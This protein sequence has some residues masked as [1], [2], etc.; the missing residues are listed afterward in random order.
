LVEAQAREAE[1]KKKEQS[2][3]TA[4]TNSDTGW[5]ILEDDP[6]R[7]AWLASDEKLFTT[8]HTMSQGWLS[9]EGGVEVSIEVHSDLKDSEEERPACRL[10]VFMG[11]LSVSASYATAPSVLLAEVA[12][13]LVP[14]KKLTCSSTPKSMLPATLSEALGISLTE[15]MD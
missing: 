7:Q 15:V 14:I 10:L 13:P 4:P 12:H 5:D 3:A 1:W 8:F 9:V 6:H 2:W 11:C